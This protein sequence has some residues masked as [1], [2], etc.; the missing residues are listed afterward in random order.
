MDGNR[1]IRMVNVATGKINDLYS[2]YFTLAAVS[3]NGAVVFIPTSGAPGAGF[4]LE[5]GFYLISP[6]TTNLKLIHKLHETENVFSLDVIWD[7]SSELFIT[8]FRCDN[9]SE[10]AVAFDLTGKEICVANLKS[11]FSPNGVWYIIENGQF[12][13]YR[14]DGSKLGE[15]NENGGNIVWNP[16]SDGFFTVINNNE[17]NYISLPSMNLQSIYKSEYGF[18]DFTWI[19]V[20]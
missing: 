8:G 6:N 11:N 13:I 18:F 17:L 9:E 4:T 10:K 1:N 3:E 14:L 7:S 12:N 5:S 15:I 20:P 19:G 16:S 2:G